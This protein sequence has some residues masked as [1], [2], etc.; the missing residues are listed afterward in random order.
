MSGCIDY[1]LAHPEM[2][3]KLDKEGLEMLLALVRAELRK[4]DGCMPPEARNDLVGCVG[5]Q[6]VRDIVNDQRRGISEPG[7]LP[8]G[9]ASPPQQRG[10]GWKQ[11][12]QLELPSGVKYVDQ[13]ADHFAELDKIDA[14]KRRV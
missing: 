14:M 10:S 13:I 2:V 3:E 4:G 9:G 8:V 5:D 1:M 6:L 12:P 7:F 11:P